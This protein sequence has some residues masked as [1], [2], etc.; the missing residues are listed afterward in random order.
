VRV[1]HTPHVHP[2]VRD[3]P[4]APQPRNKAGLIGRVSVERSSGVKMGV[5]R[6]MR[7]LSDK[8]AVMVV[9]NSASLFQASRPISHTVYTQ[10]RRTQ[11]TIKQWEKKL[12]QWSAAINRERRKIILDAGNAVQ[13]CC[14]I[15]FVYRRTLRIS[16]ICC[17]TTTSSKVCRPGAGSSSTSG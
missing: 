5:L 1:T 4:T 7:L 8:P 12:L 9:R 11:K 17:R 15:D 13:K 16:S 10:N 14:G 6:L 2:T 3:V